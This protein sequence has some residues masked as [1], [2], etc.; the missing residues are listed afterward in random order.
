[1][2]FD[3][4]QNDKDNIPFG[5]SI[6]NPVGL[7]LSNLLPESGANTHIPVSV[8]T[9]VIQIRRAHACIRIVIP[10][11]ERKQREHIIKCYPISILF[12]Q[13]PNILPTSSTFS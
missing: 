12:I 2:P 4:C 3:F 9:I 6:D 13:A 11:V 1:M 5:I 8:R 10:I 7:T